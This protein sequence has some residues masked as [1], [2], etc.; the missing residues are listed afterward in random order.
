MVGHSDGSTARNGKERNELGS[1]ELG[2]EGA[3]WGEE[4]QVKKRRD[5]GDG[6]GLRVV[7]EGGR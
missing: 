1:D 2:W 4:D 5:G 6:V 7:T 3:V